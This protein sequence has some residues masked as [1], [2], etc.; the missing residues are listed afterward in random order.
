M[1]FNDKFNNSVKITIEYLTYN[2]GIEPRK[3]EVYKG[4]YP[5]KIITKI[6][7]IYLDG[8]K[9]ENGSIY[10]DGVVLRKE[11]IDQLNSINFNFN[12]KTSKEIF[13]Y[14]IGLLKE[15]KSKK[16]LTT[17][18]RGTI[19]KNFNLGEWVT[20]IR[21]IKKNGKKLE[22]GGIEFISESGSKLLTKYEI[23]ELDKIEFIW[24]TNDYEINTTK[25]YLEK[26]RLLH[27]HLYR[28]LKDSNNQ[29]KTK[30][31]VENINKKLMKT[32]D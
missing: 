15:Y 19:F 2:K 17:I 24:D 28:I 1:S 14:N 7:T 9:L 22:D 30:K 29:I 10:L 12:R 32:L 13:D 6:R 4:I 18:T 27:V 20:Y 25:E 26:R 23:D 16:D 8:E 11:M 5:S 3:R 21:Y 31:D